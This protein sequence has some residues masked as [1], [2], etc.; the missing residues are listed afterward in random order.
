MDAKRGRLHHAARGAGP[1]VGVCLSADTRTN[2]ATPSSASDADS[3]RRQA[4]LITR[5]RGHNAGKIRGARHWRR[6]LVTILFAEAAILPP[7]REMRSSPLM[8]DRYRDATIGKCRARRRHCRFRPRVC[9]IRGVVHLCVYVFACMRVSLFHDV[10]RGGSCVAFPSSRACIASGW[11]AFFFFF[12][13]A[14]R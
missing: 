2:R 7:S 12:S 10:A 5:S 1:K 4:S 11:C 3:G 9:S 6:C 13:S 8:T 14:D